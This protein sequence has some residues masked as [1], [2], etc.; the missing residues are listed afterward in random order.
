MERGGE[1]SMW[2]GP[3]IAVAVALALLMTFQVL[4]TCSRKAITGPPIA[5]EAASAREAYSA[6]RSL[7]LHGQTLVLLDDTSHVKEFVTIR[8]SMNAIESTA[9]TPL[10]TNDNLVSTLIELGT[11]R[12]AYV[13][14]PDSKW[15]EFESKLSGSP[16]TLRS[17]TGYLRR[18]QSAPLQFDHQST[19]RLPRERTVAV[20]FSD[21]ASLYDPTFMEKV[22]TNA[23]VVVT[24]SRGGEPR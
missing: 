13:V 17:G 24:V 23:D 7:G 10:V 21:M 4:G 5:I 1:R 12:R 14:V 16:Q 2:K 18:L 8:D 19:V 15:A 3:L 6:L 11:V 20:V 9:V 22:F